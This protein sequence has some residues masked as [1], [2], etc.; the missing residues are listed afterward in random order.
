MRLIE[1]IK[2]FF[3]VLRGDEYVL[4]GAYKSMRDSY[5]REREWNNKQYFPEP[6]SDTVPQ[7]NT[8]DTDTVDYDYTL[9]PNF[10][11]SLVREAVPDFSSSPIAPRK[12]T[13]LLKLLKL[14]KSYDAVSP[15]F[16]TDRLNVS[17]PAAYSMIHDLRRRG[18][19]IER[20]NGLYIL[21]E[22]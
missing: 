9:H 6:V 21:M 20:A 13:K 5:H 15:W 2:M 1:A 7:E 12:G 4:Y 17:K 16:I 11:E 14:L 22:K 3:S 18:Y 10:A 8:T 19:K